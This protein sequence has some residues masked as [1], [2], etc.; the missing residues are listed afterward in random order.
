MHETQRS[1]AQTESR[2]RG[3]TELS[4]RSGQ[5]SDRE[6]GGH[7]HGREN[8]KPTN[9]RTSISCR[10]DTSMVNSWRPPRP[11]MG[12][13]RR[14]ASSQLGRHTTDGPAAEGREQ[15]MMRVRG[16]EGGRVGSAL[17]STAP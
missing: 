15:T 2:R 7:G 12:K 5:K 9:A 6:G 1:A 14:A 16:E 13:G 10:L 17:N 4:S 3:G 8:R 11:R